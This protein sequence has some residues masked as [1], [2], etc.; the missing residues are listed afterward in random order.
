MPHRRPRSFNASPSRP[1]TRT[2]V[3]IEPVERRLLF[4]AG[5]LDPS[6]GVGGVAVPLEA[7][8]P[9][10]FTAIDVQVTSDRI[11][12]ATSG[13]R[14]IAL[15]PAGR[16]DPTWAG[17]GTLETGL[18]S[19]GDLI[20]QPDG[21]VLAL[22]Q[23]RDT[24][25]AF[26]ARYNVNGT[27]DATFGGGDGRT[28]EVPFFAAGMALAPGGKIVVGGS[29]LGGRVA[30]TRFHPDG[31]VD[32]S[33]GGDGTVELYY[34]GTDDFGM[35]ATDVAVHPDDGRIVLVGSMTVPPDEGEGFGVDGLVVRLNPDG[36]PDT[37]FDGDGR[38]RRD[39]G[40]VDDEITAVTALPAGKLYVAPSTGE[41]YA[42]PVRL[43]ADGSDD[44]TFVPVRFD[45]AEPRIRDIHVLPDGKVLVTG[46]SDTPSD[47]NPSTFMHRYNPDGSIDPTFG[48]Y[49]FLRPI[50]AQ[51]DIDPQ[52]RIVAAAPDSQNDFTDGTKVL[53]ARYLTTGGTAT[54]VI[55]A[56]HGELAGAQVRRDHAGYT[57][58]GYVDFIGNTGDSA[59]WTV[60]VN[61]AGTHAITFRYANG[62]SDRRVMRLT[63]TGVRFSP[64]HVWFNPTGSWNTWRTMTVHVPMATPSRPLFTGFARVKLQAIGRN[65]PNID[66]LTVRRP[67]PHPPVSRE[68]QAEDGALGGDAFV[69]T[70]NGGYTGRGYVDF[71]RPTGDSLEWVLNSPT[72]RTF[73]TIIRYANGAAATR[74]LR[75][76]VNGQVVNDNLTFAPTGSWSNWWGKELTIPLRFGDNTVRLET[77]GSN[78][79]NI[80]Y[81][82]INLF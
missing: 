7:D 10:S 80:D 11:Y 13:L 64:R 82:E 45:Y 43:N 61:T 3:V 54:T 31:S 2:P 63:V 15:D 77:N 75:L 39:G 69:S 1:V 65:G 66:S 28:G 74:S 27:P 20:V 9:G 23:S 16:L 52:G 26:V 14:I 48:G 68:I 79:P 30:V 24:P 19:E 71:D 46:D 38:L 36:S 73:R 37:T 42:F 5:D 12:V 49:R 62:S 53:V 41:Q 70:L 50:G 34:R 67:T 4:A 44:P 21:K 40:H 56:E 17:D 55:Q 29:L 35:F 18:F 33:L 59:T 32:A 58:D 76:T 57:G 22:A 6:F 25:G 47:D 8:T 81:I 78:G 60:Q 72:A 51:S